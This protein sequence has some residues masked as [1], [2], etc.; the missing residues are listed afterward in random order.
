MLLECKKSGA[1]VLDKRK[2]HVGKKVVVCNHL[3]NC[4]FRCFTW[5]VCKKVHTQTN[6]GESKYCNTIHV[7]QYVQYFD[8]L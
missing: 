3:K 2:R 7:V 4:N 6:V 1:H 5:S 8:V